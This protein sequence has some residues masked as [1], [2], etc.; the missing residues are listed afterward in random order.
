MP[1]KKLSRRT[2]LTAS[3]ALAFLHTPF[4]RAI[5]ARQSVNINDYNPHDWIASFKQAFSEG[6]TVV[7]PAGLVCDN[8][9]TGIF[10]P[11]G[12]TLHILGSLRGNGRGR[13]VLQD[14]SK[15][16]GGEG[17]SIH[18]I[19][20]DVRGSDCTIKGLVMSGFGPVTQIYIGGKNKRVMRNL[21]IDNLTVSHANYAILRQG[22]HNQIIGANITNCK[23]SDLQGD[24]IEWNVAI[25]DSD[26]LISDHVIERINCTNGKIN[27]GIG[28]GLAGS[29]YDNNTPDFSKKAG[30]DNATVAIYG[31][32]NFVID[33]IEMINSA[34]MLI[35]Y[36]VIKGKYL[37]I[38]QNFRVNNIQ[39]D[40]THLAY[41]LRGIQISA[42]NAVSFVA[43]TNIE[44]KRASL[45]LHNK[46]Q[47][48][49]M[50]NIKVMQESSVGPALSMNF[51]MR[52]DVRGVF[53]AKKET[54]LS[55]AN[56][57]AVN[58]MGQS[59]VDI[60]RINHHIVN[61]EKINFRLPER[62]E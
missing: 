3:S 47:H 8:I 36:G 58:E 42:G 24:A 4:A 46:P 37:S 21:T 32:D 16:T 48:L 5:P 62:R 34:G 49:F 39:L 31:C 40:N 52:K 50:R 6:Q 45:E 20:L 12:K 54:L 57:H 44:M 30:I 59:S 10:I 11:A 19:T 33:N 25:N 38:P 35:G 53:M 51:D 13:F 26:I 41:K 1:F 7:V 18:N 28:I 29:T 15:V 23:F 55:L 9:N 2:F 61:V 43:L 27:W 22:F 17:G 60:D 56:V 14:G